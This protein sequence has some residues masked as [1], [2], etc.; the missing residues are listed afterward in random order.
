VGFSLFGGSSETTVVQT[1]NQ[2]TNV[3]VTVNP[4]FN[5]GPQFLQ[6]L[7]ETLGS[8]NQGIIDRFEPLAQGIQGSIQN[9]NRL[10][11]DLRR[12][13]DF[14]TNP[15]MTPIPS[16]PPVLLLAAALIVGLVLTKS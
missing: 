13:A 4:S 16:S 10:A 7:A 9:A 14:S 1:N 2:T 6:P 11:G 12:T 8:I 5:F 3:G 15:A